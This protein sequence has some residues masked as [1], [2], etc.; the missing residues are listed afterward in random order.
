MEK[1]FSNNKYFKFIRRGECFN[2]KKRGYGIK[3]RKSVENFL[4]SSDLIDRFR[5][6]KVEFKS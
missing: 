2:D 6:L 1:Y 3:I 4:L 5:N